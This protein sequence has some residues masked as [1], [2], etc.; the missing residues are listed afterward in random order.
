MY[1]FGASIAKDSPGLTPQAGVIIFASTDIVN[2]P[3][4]YTFK[5]TATIQGDGLTSMDRVFIP[6]KLFEGPAI[7]KLSMVADTNDSL[8]DASFDGILV[9]N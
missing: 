7:I 6:P 9:D 5:H 3:T 2:N 8:G 4:V 1:N